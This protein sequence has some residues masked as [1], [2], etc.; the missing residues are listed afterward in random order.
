[1]GGAISLLLIEKIPSKIIS[2]TNLEGNLIGED[3]TFSREAIK[4]SLEDFEKNFKNFK[5]K[6]KDT[7]DLA[8]STTPSNKLFYRWLSKSNPYAFYKSS[9]SLVKWSE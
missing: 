2:F 7:K 1:M 3:C 4:Y 6:I 5:S 8:S 9:Q